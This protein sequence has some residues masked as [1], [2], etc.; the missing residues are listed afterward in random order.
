MGPS[1]SES[2]LAFTCL[3]ALLQ[4]GIVL[5]TILMAL[6]LLKLQE[7]SDCDFFLPYFYFLLFIIFYSE[8]IPKEVIWAMTLGKLCSALAAHENH[9]KVFFFFFFFNYLFQDS[10]PRA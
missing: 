5:Q 4:S 3:F 7:T 8:K 6:M 1:S 10:I 9:W 2:C